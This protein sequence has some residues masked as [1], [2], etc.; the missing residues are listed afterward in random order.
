MLGILEMA[1]MMKSVLRRRLMF[2][3]SDLKGIQVFKIL[4]KGCDSCDR[5]NFCSF[6]RFFYTLQS[7]L[8]ICTII[9]TFK[10]FEDAGWIG[11]RQLR[12]EQYIK[13][14][15]LIKTAKLLLKSDNE[16]VKLT[17]N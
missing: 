4:I 3:S 9:H 6:N 16:V 5:S 7:N 1:G 8:Q 14:Q 12:L 13:N 15:D 17:P 10:L 2:G 11:D